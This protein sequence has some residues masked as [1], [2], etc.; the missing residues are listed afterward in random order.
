MSDFLSK[1][2][3]HYLENNVVP[4]AIQ[5]AQLSPDMGVEEFIELD[6][7]QYTDGNCDFH[8]YCEMGGIDA[9]E[10]RPLLSISFLAMRLVQNSR[11]TKI[12]RNVVELMLKDAVEFHSA[13]DLAFSTN[14]EGVFDQTYELQYQKAE[15]VWKRWLETDEKIMLTLEDFFSDISVIKL[16]IDQYFK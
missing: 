9:C 7:N 8:S 2:V 1:L 12:C 3:I 14:I 4:I 13:R 11:T 10:E 6:L 15:K 5:A 16:W